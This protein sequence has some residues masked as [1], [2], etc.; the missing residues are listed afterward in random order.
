MVLLYCGEM[1]G[2]AWTM[3]AS[4]TKKKPQRQKPRCLEEM[5]VH[6]AEN[7]TVCAFKF[8]L[9]FHLLHQASLLS[10]HFFPQFCPPPHEVSVGLRGMKDFSQCS[11][12]SL[13]WGQCR[14]EFTHSSIPAFLDKN[15]TQREIPVLGVP[16]AMYT[17]KASGPLC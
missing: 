9:H 2:F 3:Q 17:S 1:Q 13:V 5:L 12:G 4:E 11:P 6:L 7:K 15:A 8:G 16:C 14:T 10:P